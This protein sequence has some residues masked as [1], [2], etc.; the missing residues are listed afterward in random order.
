MN[1]S[2]LEKL[3]H[4]DFLTD[5]EIAK[6]Y[7]LRNLEYNRNNNNLNFDHCIISIKEK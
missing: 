2:K 1:I 3:Y 5:K 6:F 4:N 7:S